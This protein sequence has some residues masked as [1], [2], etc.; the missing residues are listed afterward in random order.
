V[1][2]GSVSTPGISW[3]LAVEGDVVYLSDGS[4]GLKVIDVSNPASPTIVG[5]VDTPGFCIGV[6]VAGDVAYLGDYGSGLQVVDVS[7]PTSP[8]IIGSESAPDL[9]YLLT[10][11]GDLVY[12]A[13]EGSGLNVIDVSDPTSPSVLANVNTPG[14]SYSVEVRGDI[15]YVADGTSGLQIID[16]FDPAFPTILATVDTPVRAFQSAISGNI[17]Y[18]ADDTAGLQVIEVFA[19]A[20]PVVLGG[21]STADRALSIAVAGDVAFVSDA[22]AGLQV[23]DV[24]DPSTPAMIGGV[25]TPG[26]SM[27][28]VVDGD[29]VYVADRSSGLQVI[30]ASDPSAPVIIGSVNTPGLSLGV[31]VVGDLAYVADDDSGLQVI[32]VFQIIDVSC[33]SSP[34]ILGTIAVP[35]IG[36]DVAVAGDV[37]YLAD[38]NLQ[39]IDVSN[40][41][42]PVIIGS[43]TPPGYCQGVAVAGDVA[44][45]AELAGLQL[46]DVSDPSSPTLLGAVATPGG[47]GEEVAVAGDVVYLAVEFAGLRSIRVGSHTF[48]V[49]SRFGASLPI[50]GGSE[51]VVK[52]RVTSENQIG[53]VRWSLSGDA[54]AGFSPVVSNGGWA[55]IQPGSDLVWRT[56]HVWSRSTPTV[57][58]AVPDVTIDWLFE[59]APIA[60]ISDVPDDQ[61]G[62]VY[63]DVTRSGYDFADEATLPVTQY[64]IY[65]RV[66][67]AAR[68]ADGPDEAEFDAS[69]LP[70]VES[71]SRAGS[72]YVVSDGKA[73]RRGAG[74][75]FPEGTWALVTSVPATQSDAYLV[76]ASTVADSTAEGGIVWSTFVVTTHTTTP[77]VWF[78]SAPASGYSI[79]NLAPGIPSGLA[80]VGSDL[81]WDT[82]SETDFEYHSVYGSE[83]ADFDPSA[84]L[85]GYAIDPMFDVSGVSYNYYHVTT[86]D[87]AGNEGDAASVEGSI[88]SA[89]DA[90]IPTS[91]ALSPP[92]PN[93]FRG[94]TA[95]TFA[96]PEVTDVRLVIYDVRGRAVRTLAGGSYAPAVHRVVWNARDD[97][98]RLVGPGVYFA[99]IEAGTFQAERRLTVIR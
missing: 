2:I 85:I 9:P 7:D 53:D 30:D 32:D 38:G 84:T 36:L 73:A 10:V 52:V 3:Q 69:P 8:V 20:S 24:S 71:Y 42:A 70:G 90:P 82:A 91:Y 74:G 92:G 34:A 4:S 26:Q 15:A 46:I 76:E 19:P 18:V 31:D 66:D 88:V 93:P 80:L 64:G 16:V 65:R 97:G 40:P 41:A 35:G 33:P 79:D 99:R 28:V 14:L 55:S 49:D 25:D 21:V 81:S 47:L 58:P 13:D 62:R 67:G 29:I 63:I 22:G 95:L 68:P 60:A 43:V 39:V 59:R 11:S 51:T 98:G 17:A 77:S 75:T 1:I 86:S 89:P 50:Y 56:D 45:V 72:R 78:A 44:Y 6:A 12:L 54:S 48:D 37:V 87:H 94:G 57:N 5:S 23:V 27:D 96:L 61:G 83:T